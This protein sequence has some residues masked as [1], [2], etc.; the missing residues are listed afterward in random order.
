MGAL[1]FELLGLGTD[2]DVGF[3]LFLITAKS[4]ADA[5]RVNFEIVGI[6]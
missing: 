5:D 3:E 6:R 1:I 2:G 4:L